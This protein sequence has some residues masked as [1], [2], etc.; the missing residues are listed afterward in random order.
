[1][2]IIDQ[3]QAKSKLLVKSLKQVVP[4]DTLKYASY[5]YSIARSANYTAQASVLPWIDLIATGKRRQS[6]KNFSEHIKSALPKMNDLLLKDAENIA[7]GYYP[8]QVLSPERPQQH[9]GRLPQVYREA[10]KASLRRK[11]NLTEDFSNDTENIHQDMPAYYSRNFHFQDS[12]YL[13]EVSADLYEHQVEMLFSGTANAMRRLIIPELKD[14]FSSEDGVG[15]HF[16]ELGV[17]RG[18]LTEFMALAFPKAK[19]TCVD[20][21]PYYLKSAQ[22]KLKKF[23]RIDYVQAKAEDLPFKNDSFD[24]VY[25]CYLFHELP[26]EVREQ[27]MKEAFRVLKNKGIVGAVDSLQLGDDSSLDWALQQFPI[28]FH[29]PFY[30][31]YTLH[32][33][34][35]LFTSTGFADISEKQGFLSKS[36]VGTK[37]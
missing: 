17:G 35:E 31:N 3:L 5:G 36:V 9:I 33:L 27:V 37:N 25:S 6:A 22:N 18:T 23:S 24:A 20:L 11:K 13:S 29:E 10:F 7:K 1:M 28:D 15:L 32:S 21:S 8:M 34:Q 14:R 19:I 16:L 12:G 2:S 26:R 30:K 4:S